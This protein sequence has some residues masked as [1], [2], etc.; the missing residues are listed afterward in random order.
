[1]VK[2]RAARRNPPARLRYEA[3]HPVVTLRLPVET[4][5][6]LKANLA[7]LGQ[8]AATWVKHHLDEDDARAKARAE[9]LARELEGLGQEFQA[10]QRRIAESKRELA[11][12]ERKKE[13]WRKEI[14][15]PI[16]AER[17]RLLREAYEEKAKVLQRAQRE[18]E[19]IVSW[20]RLQLAEGPQKAA[21]IEG[22][23]REAEARLREVKRQ[24]EEAQAALRQIEEQGEA[25]LAPLAEKA[26]ELARRKGLPSLACPS[27]PGYQWLKSTA[28]IVEALGGKVMRPSGAGGEGG[29]GGGSPK[30]EET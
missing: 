20:T 21:R 9:V 10:L 26:V 23:V 29:Q 15:A 18:A 7:S 19:E 2:G 8:T 6:R 4:H 12:L 24:V 22:Q 16:E 13:G 17:A 25:L 30:K 28:S 1:M 11:E 5:Q 27:C 14:E 3:S